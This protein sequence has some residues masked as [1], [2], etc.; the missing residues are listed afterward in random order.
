MQID[1]HEL[2]PGIPFHARGLLES[3]GLHEHSQHPAGR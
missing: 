3:D 2:L 1:T